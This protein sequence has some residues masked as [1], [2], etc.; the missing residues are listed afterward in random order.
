MLYPLAKRLIDVFGAVV[1]LLIAALLYIPL[2]IAIKLESP[3]PVIFLQERLGKGETIFRICKFRTMHLN[4]A[5]DDGT[6]PKAGDERVTRMGRFLRRTSLDEL[7]QFWNV[8]RGEMSLVGP[9]PEQLRFAHYY[10]GSQRRRFVVKPGLTGWWQVS[11]RPQPM[12]EHIEYD[13]YYV[14]HCSLRLDLVILM[15]TARAIVSGEGA[16]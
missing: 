14:D 6:K 15:R 16:V 3:G 12:Y 10:A 11:G 4:A 5:I 9:R 2:A 7:P 1:G 13:L 8:L